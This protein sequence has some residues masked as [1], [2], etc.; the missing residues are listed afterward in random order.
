M[1]QNQTPMMK[2]YLGLKRNHKDEIL[3]FRMGD[4]YEMFYED[5]QIA[6]KILDIALTA[7]QNDIPMCGIPHHAA[8]SYIARLIKAGE[9]VAICEQLESVPS[10]GTIVKRDV[11]RII[12][13]GTIIEQ[14]LLQSDDNNFLSSVI[15]EKD[16]IGMAFID[17]STGDFFLSSI[18]KNIEIFRGEITKFNP[19]EIVLKESN[20]DEDNVYT[21]FIKSRNTPIYKINEWLYDTDYMSE[22]ICKT[23]NLI[24]T[25]GLGITEDI[26]L[27]TAGS[28]LQYIKETH[29]K[30]FTHLKH[31][32]RTISSDYMVLDD[33]TISNLELV[34]NILDRTKN[35]TL[36]SVINY[37]KTPMG[38]RTLEKNLYQPLLK[39]IEIENRL[40]YVEFFV[41]SID[42][43]NQS[44]IT[45][46][47]LRHT[48][49]SYMVARGLNLRTIM[50]AVGIDDYRTLLIYSQ[51]VK[52]LKKNLPDPSRL[53]WQKTAKKLL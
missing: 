29:K 44:E 38:R 9:R 25:K 43:T 6:S 17:I 7:R 50:D 21:E 13:P 14:N 10:S 27:I 48:H 51:A 47:T 18:K 52:N 36:F 2:Q 49:I 32:E 12:T 42:I 15:F 30:I 31:P 22:L 11:V 28:I 46:H 45:P 37:T 8:D 39:K 40:E 23:F 1:N 34:H 16:K 20:A 3:F 41:N 33:S 53:P 24:S 5:A 19:T 4:F 26:E 35:R